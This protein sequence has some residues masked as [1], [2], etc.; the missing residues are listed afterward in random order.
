MLQFACSEIKEVWKN[1]KYLLDQYGEDLE[2]DTDEE[3]KLA[4]KMASNE[5]REL[6]IAKSKGEEQMREDAALQ[7]RQG[8]MS[9]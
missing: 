9:L 3:A 8:T 7:R 5:M 6:V 1:L 2:P 4:I